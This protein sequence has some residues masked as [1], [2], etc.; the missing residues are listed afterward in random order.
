VTMRDGFQFVRRTLYSATKPKQL[1]VASEVVTID[2]LQSHSIP[3][4]ETHNYSAT[5]ENAAGTEHMFMELVQGTNL[6]DFWLDLSREARIDVVKK[7]IELE[8][9]LLSL[10]FLTSDSLYYTTDLP[11]GLNRVDIPT[12]DFICKRRFCIGPDTRLGLW[13]KRR[14]KDPM[15]N[16]F[17]R[18]RGERV[19][20][21]E[22]CADRVR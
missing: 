6:G 18:R 8:S 22:C 3:V 15:S 2:F 13:H 20:A 17:L 7:L 9:R 5:S 11:S 12:A 16:Q 14:Y 19:F 10:S 21:L 1:V 4:P